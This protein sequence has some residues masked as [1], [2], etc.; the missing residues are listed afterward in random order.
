M[1]PLLFKLICI[2]P[3]EVP[4][5][6]IVAQVEKSLFEKKTVEKAVARATKDIKKELS[7]VSETLAVERKAR[8]ALQ[9]ALASEKKARETLQ[10]ALESERRAR[11]ALQDQLKSFR[12]SSSTHAPPSHPPPHSSPP[13][14]PNPRFSMEV[15]N[16]VGEGGQWRR[17][18]E[19]LVNK[20][21][22]DT[23]KLK[24]R[25]D[26]LPAESGGTPKEPSFKSNL[27]TTGSRLY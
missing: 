9:E 17:D 23:E 11:E 5:D 2:F 18:L 20:L 13:L 3:A 27:R 6:D 14:S 24:R 21:L 16:G 12:R 25:V 19:S 26:K 15:A 7:H 8:E 4:S 1:I 10:E 22:D